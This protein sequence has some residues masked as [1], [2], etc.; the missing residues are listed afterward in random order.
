LPRPSRD[1]TSTGS[2]SFTWR[3]N[4]GQ[5]QHPRRTGLS[6]GSLSHL[7]RKSSEDRLQLEFEF[8]GCSA[9]SSARPTWPASDTKAGFAC[10]NDTT[11]VG[12]PVEPLSDRDCSGCWPTFRMAGSTVSSCTRR[13]LA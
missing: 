12:S 10:Q 6:A 11:M 2:G 13:R 7:H 9:G 5:T 3:L 1:P 4:D 8:A